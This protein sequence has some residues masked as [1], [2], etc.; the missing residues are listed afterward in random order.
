MVCFFILCSSSI[1]TNLRNKRYSIL[2]TVDK[3]YVLTLVLSLLQYLQYLQSHYYM[4]IINSYS[5]TMLAY[6]L[7]TCNKYMY[8]LLDLCNILA[9]YKSNSFHTAAAKVTKII[10]SSSTYHFH[11]RRVFLTLASLCPR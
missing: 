4:Y 3:I 10:S 2:Y 9:I 6:S 5:S 8:D 1:I 11:T 7:R